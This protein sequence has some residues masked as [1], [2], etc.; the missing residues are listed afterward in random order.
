ME[1]GTERTF[2]VIKQVCGNSHERH[3]KVHAHY[4]KGLVEK[5][6]PGKCGSEENLFA[7]KIKEEAQI[8][9]NTPTIISQPA[10]R[11]SVEDWMGPLWH[12]YVAGRSRI[13]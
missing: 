12:Y 11:D 4:S 6:S 5:E 9:L 8:I 1:N 2:A 3:A 10:D 13:R 7:S